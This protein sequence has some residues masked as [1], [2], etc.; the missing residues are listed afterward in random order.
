MIVTITH[1]T[2]SLPYQAVEAPFDTIIRIDSLHNQII[3]GL[4][5]TK[6]VIYPSILFLM[7]FNICVHS[8]TLSHVRVLDQVS[9]VLLA[10][11]NNSTCYSFGNGQQSCIIFFL[12]N[13]SH[14]TLTYLIS[15]HTHMSKEQGY[16]YQASPPGDIPLLHLNFQMESRSNASCIGRS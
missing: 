14:P 11:C 16:W 5:Y 7:V 10:F 15:P 2:T 9:H 3:L 8:Q 12:R 1:V 6:R 4:C 13:L